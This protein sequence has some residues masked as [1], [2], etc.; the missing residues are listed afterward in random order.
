[1]T[2]HLFLAL[3]LVGCTDFDPGKAPPTDD[4]TSSAALDIQPTDTGIAGTF[5]DTT[6]TSDMVSDHVLDIT[7]HMNGMVITADVD[8]LAGVIE[9][10]GYTAD[11]GENTQM[12]D[13]D[14][15]T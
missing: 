9:T 6:F 13:E 15:A 10:D 8:F 2:K 5:G 1:M 3:A 7:I 11:T 4:T 14:R 12:T